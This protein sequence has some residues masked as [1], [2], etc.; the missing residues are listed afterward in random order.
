MLHIK[1]KVLGNIGSEFNRDSISNHLLQIGF[2]SLKVESCRKGL[3][4][5]S[6]KGC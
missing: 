5:C 6:F 3:Y 2:A 1:E 4:A